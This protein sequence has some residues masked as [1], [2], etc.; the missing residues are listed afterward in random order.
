M[1]GS[2]QPAAPASVSSLDRGADRLRESAKWLVASFGAAAAVVLAGINFSSIGSLA[3]DAPDF[4]FPVAVAGSVLALAG[5]LGALLASMS[6]ASAS[7][8]TV[9]DLRRSPTRWDWSLDA[10]RRAIAADPVLA[11]WDQDFA[12]LATNYEAAHRDWENELRLWVEAPDLDPDTALLDRATHRLN[13]LV[14]LVGQLLETASF[15]RLQNSF[16]IFRFAIGGCLLVAGGGAVLVVWAAN[17]PTDEGLDVPSVVEAR[18]DVPADS[19]T[20]Y[21]DDLGPAC[22][23]MLDA[24][25]VV[26]LDIDDAERTAEILTLPETGCSTLRRTVPIE[27]LSRPNPVGG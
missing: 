3:P 23:Y 22:P 21:R 15:L 17:P 18:F 4:R 13:E 26:V 10:A 24:L 5:I 6:L 7:T 2:D 1:A 14:A 20:Q 16:R 9:D 25:P 11:P 8:V 27:R 12:E 19:V